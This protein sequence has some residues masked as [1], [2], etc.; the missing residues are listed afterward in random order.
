[1]CRCSLSVEW[2]GDMAL[3]LP[4]VKR[5]RAEAAGLGMGMK[6]GINIITCTEGSEL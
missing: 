1:M 5:G 4:W 2:Q 6:G 3:A